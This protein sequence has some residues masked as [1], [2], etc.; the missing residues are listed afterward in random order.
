M[1][2]GDDQDHH[3]RHT[4][5]PVYTYYSKK[6]EEP[7]EVKPEANNAQFSK[8]ELL[9]GILMRLSGRYTD[10]EI[11][12]LETIH[13]TPLLLFN[14]EGKEGHY[15]Q[16]SLVQKLI[17]QWKLE[18]SKGYK[19]MKPEEM[20][21]LE[22][23]AEE[24]EAA[25]KLKAKEKA[26]KK[27]EEAKAQMMKKEIENMKE[28]AEGLENLKDESKPA[29]K[30]YYINLKKIA[31][32]PRIKG[33]LTK[34][35]G[36]PNGMNFVPDSGSQVNLISK[37]HFLELG[38]KMEEIDM[39]EP[40]IICG[41][42]NKKNK[43]SGFV[44]LDL[45]LQGMDNKFYQMPKMPF[46]VLDGPLD[47]V[48]IGWPGH[49]QLFHGYDRGEYGKNQTPFFT[50]CMY[51][52]EGLLQEKIPFRHD[53]VKKNCKIVNTNT[54][55]LSEQPRSISFRSDG[56]INKTQI[57]SL[58]NNK[59][60][61]IHNFDLASNDLQITTRDDGELHCYYS[62]SVEVSSEEPR[63]LEAETLE[64]E[65]E[66]V[67]PDIMDELVMVYLG[68]DMGDDELPVMENIEAVTTEQIAVCVDA[69]FEPN[70]DKWYIPEM[71]HLPKN[72]QD[73]FED[74]FERFK[75]VFSKDKFDIAKCNVPKAHIMTE[76][77][78]TAKD[79]PARHSE[80]EGDII[81][82]YLDEMLKSDQI[83][84]LRPD[85]YSEWNHRLL[86]VFRNEGE[87]NFLSSKADSQTMTREERIEHLKKG[88]RLVSDVRNLNSISVKAGT[89]YLPTIQELLPT[90]GFN[91]K[92]G[93]CCSTTDIRSGFS[94]IELDYR[95][96]LKTAFVHRG[97]KYCY[98]RMLQGW[99]N[100]PVIFQE[101]LARILNRETFQEFL[102]EKNFNRPL[103]FEK[104]LIT[105]LDDICL[106]GDDVD[107]HL[108]VWEYMLTRFKVM[109]LKINAKKTQIMSENI[110]FL[111]YQITPGRNEYGLTSERKAAFQGW[112]FQANRE[113]L[114]SRLCTLNYFDT[115]IPGFKIITQCLNALVREKSMVVEKFH[116]KEFEM[117]KLLLELD[118]TFMIPDLTRP[119]ILS[120][121]ASF[122]CSAACLM[123]YD[124][125]EGPQSSRLRLCSVNTKQFNKADI[126]KAIVH[127]ETLGFRNMLNYYKPYVSACQS[128][129]V[130]FTDAACLQFLHRYRNTHSPL[131]S[132]S[133]NISAFKNLYVFFS[134]GSW[135]NSLADNLSR[136]T[137]GQKI[138]SIAAIPKE[139]LENT[140]PLNLNGKLVT[141][142]MLLEICSRPLPK[143]F[144]DLPARHT[145]AF[146]TFKNEEDMISQLDKPPAEKEVLDAIF[147]GY[148]SIPKDSRIFQNS[149]TG[150]IIAKTDFKALSQKM[151]FPEIKAKLLFVECMCLHNDSPDEFDKEAR[152]W[153]AKLN[154][155]LEEHKDISEENFKNRLV[156]FLNNL[157]ISKED[158]KKLVDDFRY[159]SLYNTDLEDEIDNLG[160]HLFI[161]VN[162][163]DRSAVQLSTTEEEQNRDLQ[164]ELYNQIII[165]PGDFHVVM[166][167]LCLNTKYGSSYEAPK[168][169]DITIQDVWQL[170]DNEYVMRYLLIQNL[171]DKDVILKKGEDMGSI[172][173]HIIMNNTC[174]CTKPPPITYLVRS[175][176]TG[177]E[178][179][180]EWV[181]GEVQVFLGSLLAEATT[182][183]DSTSFRDP[184]IEEEGVGLE[185]DSS[186]KVES[187]NEEGIKF[188]KP[189]SK[190]HLNS[191]LY[192]NISVAG[193]EMFSPDFFKAAQQSSKFLQDI[194]RKIELGESTRFIVKDDL[195]YE[196]HPKRG[197]IICI[198]DITTIMYYESLHRNGRH[199]NQLI[200]DRH[201]ES[202]F[203]NPNY[204]KYSKAAR[205]NCAVCTMN[206]PCKKK[207]FTM[208][209]DEKT[210]L[211]VWYK[212]HVDA[213]ENLPRANS[214]KKYLIIYVC[215]SSGFT[216]ARAT[217]TLNASEI[218][219]VTDEVL[220]G[221]S[222]CKIMMTDFGPAFRSREFAELME[223]WKINHSKFTPQRPQE[224]GIAEAGVKNFRERL[225]N[226][227]LGDGFNARNDW[228]KYLTRGV[229]YF[230]NSPL[231]PSINTVTRHDMMFSN[232][233]YH[234]PKLLNV[235]VFDSPS[236]D[237]ER[238][239]AL[240][241]IFD[242]RAKRRESFGDKK[243]KYEP[244]QLVCCPLGKTEHSRINSGRGF[245]P[246]VQNYFEVMEVN[247]NGCRLKSLLDQS[248]VSV[249]FDK[250]QPC[251]QHEITHFIGREPLEES[252]FIKNIYKHKNKP[253]LLQFID[254]VNKTLPEEKQMPVLY[255]DN[256]DIEQEESEV[257]SESSEV[258]DSEPEEED[259]SDHEENM[260]TWPT[261]I[262][263]KTKDSQDINPEN[264]W[265]GRLRQRK[266]TYLTYVPST[267]QSSDEDD[268]LSCYSSNQSHSS[269]GSTSEEEYD[270]SETEGYDTPE[271]LTESSD[272]EDDYDVEDKK[273][274]TFDN[275]TQVL[276]FDNT[277]AVDKIKDEYAETS[278][279]LTIHKEKS[280]T[281]A[282]AYLV[283]EWG[284]SPSEAYLWDLH[285]VRRIL[286]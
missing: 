94:N 130:A 57:K 280:T 263:E 206:I 105:Y 180:D 200:M 163:S 100:A 125:N 279:K 156:K 64:V 51:D 90:F 13:D 268:Y 151:K 101:R 116:V 102:K 177:A 220:A 126:H 146:A 241:K 255:E 60:Y 32:L 194:R 99:T 251:S 84:K 80:T 244:G 157:K 56:P 173:M 21:E 38:R 175:K 70:K 165:S 197:E 184:E 228:D 278:E 108:L 120:T 250:I 286:E 214:G 31:C 23:L 88:S 74:V 153:A 231:Y 20:A 202:M 248:E 33:Y 124:P 8:Y 225:E 47:Q 229:I 40:V 148:E 137:A 77:G 5:A 150:R 249:G 95:S 121:D 3:L 42:S 281:R 29:V 37:K 282:S 193:V 208:N 161:S 14:D 34:K 247:P 275:N 239:S 11:K 259:T 236:N 45:N 82:D 131:Y 142:S 190:K 266:R 212:V 138:Q 219:R 48:L 69:E 106:L 188:L 152:E 243:F 26:I 170:T 224:N 283:Q 65:L 195:I 235:N 240:H 168:R 252:T 6:K 18:I 117:M 185:E 277:T 91:G 46:Y 260:A 118:I 215:A 93:K 25:N 58:S 262:K 265:E 86:L 133:I 68:Q 83:R 123:Q 112:K 72:V 12:Y 234:T 205:L 237:G 204:K 27:R 75:D 158:F 134:K 149:K 271:S 261:K 127:K 253:T 135:L 17:K 78:K 109:G 147:F 107:Q 182:E 273:E 61:K 92:E 24:T 189:I 210:A 111:G 160:L 97:Q 144:S 129:V 145:Q 257:E 267:D 276:K 284:I 79:Q 59:G 230:N 226:I 166:T 159:T 104:C 136:G 213:V 66:H 198:D 63:S 246:N 53:E 172:K 7:V 119:L 1:W 272:K 186:L 22:R 169:K 114:V 43:P 113:Y 103:V 217:R 192:S 218:T 16:I 98:T 227:I 209:P 62:C 10:D 49:E 254:D 132:M 141:P 270:T 41:V 67:M 128:S 71:K 264:V 191:L 256:D 55:T 36:K 52:Q 245:Q 85:E 50:F 201:F 196:K 19:I 122:T 203:S 223:F 28:A 242:I 222:I 211:P 87:K 233:K 207:N 199:Y 167:E 154:Q 15:T 221:F 238:R 164:I 216:Q 35:G 30:C 140:T 76:P 179:I 96:Q 110:N 171:T 285:R 155:Y 44:Y 269:S 176:M 115:C 2:E 162:Q 178:N 4:L 39:S 54:V 89:M 139:Y 187:E 174:L 181:E 258:Y 9:H 81:Q 232:L 274:V 73:K 183:K 143:Y